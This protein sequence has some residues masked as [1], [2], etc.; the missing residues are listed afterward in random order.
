MLNCLTQISF[1]KV[2]SNKRIEKASKALSKGILNKII[3]FVLFLLGAN[4]KDIS[5]YLH[6]PFGTLLSFLTRIEKHKLEAFSDRRKTATDKH[7]NQQQ[8]DISFNIKAQKIYIQAGGQSKV[9]NIPA[10]NILQRKIV[11]LS[12]FNSNLLSSKEAAGAIGISERHIWNLSTKIKNEDIYS[13]IDKRKG[14]SSDY[15]V[16]PDIKA[17]LIQQ[18]V[19]AS[20]TNQSTSG[21]SLSIQLKERCNLDLS[22]RTIRCHIKKLGLDKIKSTLPL[23]LQDLKK[24]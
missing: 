8:N 3:A 14:Q 4:R 11:I 2:N 19:L 10:E 6:I 22:G 7:T 17:E 5:N 20:I 13:I 12:L 23:L 1:S 18:Y 15:I 16:T 9:L 24:T 21:N